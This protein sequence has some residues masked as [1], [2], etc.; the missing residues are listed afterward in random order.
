MESE[1]DSLRAPPLLGKRIAVDAV[2]E[3]STEEEIAPRRVIRRSK[4][5][6]SQC[7]VSDEERPTCDSLTAGCGWTV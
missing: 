6:R 3:T 5:T 7:I 1:V 2:Q 4:S